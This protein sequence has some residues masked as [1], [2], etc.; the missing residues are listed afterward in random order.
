VAHHLAKYYLHDSFILILS[1]HHNNLI[2]I[3]IGLVFF[4]RFFFLILGLNFCCAVIASLL[5][6]FSV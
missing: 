1:C 5:S 4:T 3:N 2:D 6:I